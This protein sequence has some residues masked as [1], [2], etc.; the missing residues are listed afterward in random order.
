L[1]TDSISL[2]LNSRLLIVFGSSAAIIELSFLLG[3]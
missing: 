3:Y 1:N 2:M